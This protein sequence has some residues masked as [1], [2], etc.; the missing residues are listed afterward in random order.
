MNSLVKRA[1]SL[2]APSMWF[3]A[4]T[5]LYIIY[6]IVVSY[7]DGIYPICFEPERCDIFMTFV[8]ISL[9]ILVMIL[10][11]WILN[12]I[13]SYGYNVVAWSLFAV[14]LI[15]RHVNEFFIDITL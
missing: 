2:C 3:L 12:V 9:A 10:F 14:L 4:L 11:T 8:H 6:G 1:T 13:C 5:S 15:S 7:K